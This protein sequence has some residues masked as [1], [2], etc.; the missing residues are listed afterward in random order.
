MAQIHKSNCRKCSIVIGFMLIFQLSNG[1]DFSVVDNWLQ[2]NIKNLGGRAILIV[3]HNGEIVYNQSV[4]EL[5]KKQKIVGKIIG[6][7]KG[8]S[9]SVALQDFSNETKQPIASCSKWLS[10]ALAMTFIDKGEMQL[11]DSVGKYLPILTQ[12]GKGNITIEQCLSHLT[13]IKSGSL[14]EGI[15]EIRKSNSMEEAIHSIAQN[16]MEGL[17]GKTFRYS[18][19]GLQI[20]AAIMEK[21]SN[22]DFETLIKERIA[23]PCEMKNTDF[24]HAKVPL[25]AGGAWSTTNDYMQFL[26]MLLQD[27]YYNGKQVLSKNSIAEMQINRLTEDVVIKH[28][29][30]EANS[31]GYGFGEWVMN[32][33]VS[34]PGLFGSFPWINTQKKY[35][36]FLFTLNL[37]SKGRQQ[38]YTELRKMIDQIIY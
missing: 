14:K 7:K 28:S 30:D 34:S 37:K 33:A 13:G 23:L 4:N 35:A 16:P 38:R 29:P 15:E 26:V 36:A 32:N 21:I 3:H 11:D 20:V 2:D 31:W 5:S 12:N 8:Q 9:P 6:R 17:P 1:Q 27:G 25:A 18:N 19:V 22:K 10:A 24:G